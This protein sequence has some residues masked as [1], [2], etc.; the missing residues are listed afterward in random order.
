MMH[1]YQINIYQL[2]R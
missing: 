1:I 2:Q